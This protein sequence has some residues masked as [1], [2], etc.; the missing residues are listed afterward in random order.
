MTSKK[1]SE[2]VTSEVP[3]RDWVCLEEGKINSSGRVGTGTE[4]RKAL[5]ETHEER[6]EE[7]YK[8]PSRQSSEVRK[9]RDV[10]ATVGSYT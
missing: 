10:Q 8:N 9:Q 6:G 4:I 5:I 2:S 3:K 7:D 1:N